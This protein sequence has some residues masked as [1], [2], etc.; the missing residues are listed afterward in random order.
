MSSTVIK[1]VVE[2]RRIDGVKGI[3]PAVAPAIA[4]FRGVDKAT[5]N[6]KRQQSGV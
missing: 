6:R 3:P 4:V 1:Y 5:S 2:F